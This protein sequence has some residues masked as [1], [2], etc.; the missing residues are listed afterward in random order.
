MTRA[1]SRVGP[2]VA[3]V[4]TAPALDVDAL[5]DDA[6]TGIIVCCGSGGVGKTTTSAALAIRAA[7]R[8][9][10]VVVLT[11][12]PARR[13]AQAMGIE[14]LDNTPR[15]V[16]GA[17]TGSGGS[18]D[19]MMLDMK[20]TF[21]E[22]VESQATPEKAKQILENPF[23]IALSSSFAGTQE[24]MAMEKLGQLQREAQR[25]GT[26]DLIVVDT[27]P[28][29]SALD[30]LD[31]PE[32]LSSFL[33]GRFV[34]LLLAPARGPARIMSAGFGLLTS[35]LSR[36]LGGQFLTDLQTFV[37]ALDTVFGGF[38]QRAQQT[39]ALL[40]APGTA[41]LVVA[42]P[43]PDALREAAYFVERLSEER[44]PLAGLIVN[45]ASPTP[46]GT[47]SADEAMTASARLQRSTASSPTATLTAGLLRL[48]ADRTRMVE[49]EAA[50]RDRFAAAHPQ[51]ATAVVPALAGDVHDLDG[52]RVVGGLLAEYGAPE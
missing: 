51:V 5:L 27:P 26:Y 9:R 46:R 24:Y 31:A 16:A 40:Q 13:L 22:V 11:I 33:D 4:S 12:D 18:L 23:Y 6:R 15:P 36:I 20:R 25:S 49:R 39:Y 35:A 41:F 19:A 1:R 45:R 29:R 38:R 47:L 17:A 44:M 43:E 14:A 30:F 37:S 52:L 8:G 2:L 48:H 42:A 10:K 34:R 28:S 50:L 21:D 7:E 3:P 32:R